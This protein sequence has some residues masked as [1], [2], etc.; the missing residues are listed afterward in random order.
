MLLSLVT[1][2]ALAADPVALEVIPRA[3]KGLGDPGLVLV[4]NQAA[5]E[6]ETKV[7]CGGA[8]AG[9]NGPAQAGERITLSLAVNPGH[10]TC[11]GNLRALFA[12]GS[13]GEMPLSF[14]ID[15]FDALK[16]DVPRESVDVESRKLSVVLDRTPG[17]VDVEVYGPRDALL[18]QA[19]TPGLGAAAGD[20]VEIEWSGEGEV[21]RIHVKGTDEH[22]FW[23]AVD[24]FPWSYAIPHEDVVF[25]SNQSLIRPDE[26]PKLTAA[27]EEVRAVQEKYGPNVPM[28]LYVAGYTDTVGDPYANQQLSNLR[29]ASIAAWFRDNGFEGSVWYQ[30]FGEEALAVPTPDSTDEEKNRRALYVLAA[31]TPAVSAELPRSGWQKL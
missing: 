24:L 16:V 18:G 5:T 28:N 10:Y 19:S 12:D 7:E 17:S 20:P 31:E 2:A 1:K 30:G 25:D 8:W 26:E 3:Q 27:M 9:H 14:E 6:L 15:M 22:G 11:T 21:V 13:E 23:T 4:V 29:A